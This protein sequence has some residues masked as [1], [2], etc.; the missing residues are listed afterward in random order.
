MHKDTEKIIQEQ[1]SNFII[2]RSYSRFNEEKGRRETWD[3]II[4]RYQN[5]LT[6]KIPLI[7]MSDFKEA[8]QAIRDKQIMPSMRLL[9]SAGPATEKDEVAS[10]NCAYT[11]IDSLNVFSEIMYLLMNGVG[12]GFSVERQYINKL[13]EVSTAKY[14][15]QAQEYIVEDSKEGWSLTFKSLIKDWYKGIPSTWDTSKVRPKGSIIKCF[16]GRASGP[17]VLEDLFNFTKSII[18]YASGRKLNSKELADIVCKIADIVIAGGV[19]RSAAI[20]F[21]NLSDQRMKHYKEGQFWLENPQRALAN[22]S[23]A[24]T[25]KPDPVIFIEEFKSLIQS[26]VGERGIVN[27]EIFPEEDLRM[28]PCQPNYAT[29]LTPEGIRTFNDIDIGSIIW[30]SEGWTKVTQK[31]SSGMKDVYSY[32]TTSG[33]FIGTENHRIIQKGK[34]C[35]VYKATSIDYLTGPKDNYVQEENTQLIVDGLVLGDG[36]YHKASNKISLYIG[37]K[38]L[39]YFK[40]KNLIKYMGKQ[41]RIHYPYTY[42]ITTTITPNEL[43]NTYNRHIPDRFLNMS[44]SDTCS[45]LKGL[46]S[47]NGSNHSGRISYKSTS[48][49]V[50]ELI[51]LLLSSVG[52][53]SYYTTNKEKE[54]QLTNGSYLCKK[55]Y[56]L[57]IR[58]DYKLFL[59]NIGFIQEYKKVYKGKEKSFNHKTCKIISKTFIENTE[60]FNIT[61]DNE[62]HT[63]WTGGLNVS[64]CGERI[65]KNKQLCNLSEVVIESG[66]SYVEIERRA[67]LAT[68]L[69]TI[70]ASLT[71]FNTKILS[72]A[73]IKNSEDDALLGVSLTG[74]SNRNWTSEE[75]F[76]LQKYCVAWNEIYSRHLNINKAKGI[77]CN[78]PSGSVSQVVGCSSGIHPDYAPYYI[79]RVR[80]AVTDPI[81]KLLV[82]SGIPYNPDVGTTMENAISYVFEFP[83]KG[84]AL[85]WKDTE[86]ALSQLEY[87]K[88]FKKYWCDNRGNPSCTVYVKE[89]EWV[90][91]MNWVYTNWEHIGGLSFLPNDGGVYPL[92]PYEEI[93]K[94]KYEQLIKNFPNIDFDKLASYE[95]SDY[96][97]GAKEYAC[98]AGNCE[99]I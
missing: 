35:E 80:V 97:V 6:P 82:D 54:I 20:C 77:T 31:S 44:F 66:I 89:N 91:V 74:T 87:Y 49:P 2:L 81:S 29:V 19:R 33:K 48:L 21:S 43:V 26:K 27:S 98:S 47:A 38:D 95:S 45:F 8:I 71:K 79:R 40:D 22:I 11:A 68:L 12:V 14:P 65:L 10:F 18:H 88:L 59:E 36:S 90:E 42:D 96:T 51:Q 56:D 73:W 15:E 61:V 46:Y 52:I 85:R 9:W 41:N 55:S 92:A 72:K 84:H 17:G 16:G 32:N 23:V 34:K 69:G 83:L 13:P 5:F 3:E 93:T 62:S 37:R 1:Y 30:S 78:K 76:F 63:Y 7:L 53:K 70:Q 24:Y 67:K 75:L 57:N 64:N 50:I 94:D 58:A 86:T 60:V 99:L 39:D 25:E 28:N 4:D